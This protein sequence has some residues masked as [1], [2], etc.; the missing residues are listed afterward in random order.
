MA[1][2]ET[3]TKASGYFR[4]M[5]NG[6]EIFNATEI[7]IS[8]EANNIV[9]SGF[10]DSHSPNYRSIDV[11]IDSQTPTGEQQFERGKLLKE[12]IYKSDSSLMHAYSGSFNADLNT[13]TK[14]YKLTFTLMFGGQSSA[15]EGEIDVIHLID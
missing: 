4:A 10:I 12:V 8:N 14:H 3:R 15:I 2:N 9:I 13:T 6:E 1:T 7:F 5:Q 11:L